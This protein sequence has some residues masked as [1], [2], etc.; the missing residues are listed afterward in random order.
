MVYCYA[1]VYNNTRSGVTMSSAK[2]CIEYI[3]TLND[4]P[5][6]T[7]TRFQSKTD[8]KKHLVDTLIIDELPPLTEDEQIKQMT[9]FLLRK[10]K[11]VK[12]PRPALTAE[13][14]LTHNNHISEYDD[15]FIPDY[16]VYTDG[17]C[18]K[19]GKMGAQAGYGIYFGPND[20]R[21]VAQKLTGESQTNNAAELTAVIEVYKIIETDVVQNNKKVTIVTDSTYAI[22]CATTYGRKCHEERWVSTA[23]PNKEL[24]KSA[25]YLYNRLEAQTNIRFR[26]IRAHTTNN[27]I[28]S[29]GNQEA[30]KLAV[31]GG[32]IIE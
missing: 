26:H 22:Y 31:Q 6:A 28:H 17:S 23:M 4:D 15:G 2:K 20:D 14:K 19:N 13:E 30:D 1:I 32:K 11:K 27:D 3:Q 18:K 7:Y 8:A 10:V 16:Y 24:V 25:F 5:S 29:I 12:K 21:N 9:E